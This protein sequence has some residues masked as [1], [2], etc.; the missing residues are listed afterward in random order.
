VTSYEYQDVWYHRFQSKFENT[1]NITIHKYENKRTIELPEIGGR[2][3][4]LAF[5]DSPVG[6]SGNSREQYS[7]LNTC[8]AAARHTD[9][10]MLHDTQRLGERN[11]LDL[12]AERG[13]TITPVDGAGRLSLMSHRD[14][15]NK[16]AREQ[17]VH[18]T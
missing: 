4:D 5:V 15:A 11:T 14:S 17:V 9:R 1:R 3:F 13:W 16:I 2:L 18:L 7:R 8:E 6:L 12:F 10:I